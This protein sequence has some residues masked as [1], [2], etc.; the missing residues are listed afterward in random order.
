[1]NLHAGELYIYEQNSFGLVLASD[2][3]RAVT[4]W[5]SD[6]NAEIVRVDGGG[7]C[8]GG[9]KFN[10]RVKAKCLRATLSQVRDVPRRG[11]PSSMGMTD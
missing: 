10:I 8:G 1:V 3:D 4:V 2:K 7:A 11:A 6:H 5:A 9:G